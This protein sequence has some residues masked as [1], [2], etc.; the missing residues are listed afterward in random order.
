MQ[1]IPHRI[2]H[3]TRTDPGIR[4]CQAAHGPQQVQAMRVSGKE[5]LQAIGGSVAQASS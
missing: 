2:A 3:E 4:Q 1:G 5:L